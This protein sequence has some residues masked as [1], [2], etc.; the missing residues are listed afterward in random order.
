MRESMRYDTDRY[1]LRD[2]VLE[3]MIEIVK[4]NRVAIKGGIVFL[5]RFFNTIF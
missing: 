5:W 3:R 2:Y 4:Q 1:Q